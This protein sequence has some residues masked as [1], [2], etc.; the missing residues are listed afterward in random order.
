MGVNTR[1]EWTYLPFG[2]GMLSD[3]FFRLGNESLLKLTVI[4]RFYAILSQRSV[5]WM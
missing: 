1:L 5:Y 4:A 3:M 2:F